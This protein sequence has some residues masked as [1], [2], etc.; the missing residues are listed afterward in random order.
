MRDGPERIKSRRPQAPID[1]KRNVV[2]DE[3]EADE[4]NRD[5]LAR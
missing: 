5:S 1:Q 3:N 2:A 4:A